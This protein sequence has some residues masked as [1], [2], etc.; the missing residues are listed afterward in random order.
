MSGWRVEPVGTGDQPQW[1]IFTG[2][3]LNGGMMP[4][5]PQSGAP[6]HWLVYFATADIDATAGRMTDL[7][8]RL[9]VPPMDIP[10]GRIWWRWTPTPPPSPCASAT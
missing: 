7:G 2:P 5:P 4:L 3:G 1:G 8:G 10:G 6:S 9:V